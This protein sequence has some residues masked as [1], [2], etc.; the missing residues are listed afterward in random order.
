MLLV[1]VDPQY[2]SSGVMSMIFEKSIENAI[3]N[4][5][6]HAET[7]PELEYNTNV[8]SLWKMFDAENHKDRVCWLKPIE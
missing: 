3:K 1:A 4:G 7:G 2:Q 8:Q 5:I 6:E